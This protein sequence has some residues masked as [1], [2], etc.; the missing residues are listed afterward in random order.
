MVTMRKND[1]YLDDEMVPDGTT[2]KVPVFAMD[3]LQRA[4]GGV[5]LSGHQPGYRTGMS[6]A[7]VRDARTAARDAR[8]GYV[9]R[10]CEAWRTAG[11][12]Q[13]KQ[14]ADPTEPDPSAANAVEE[15]LE[16]WQGRD[17]ADLARDVERRRRAQHAEFCNTLSNAWRGGR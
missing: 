13:S 1:A 6:N 7:A 5:D 3:A 8:N 11:R 9:R 14:D 17:P 4:V 15:Q 16:R 10:T 2:L 12:V